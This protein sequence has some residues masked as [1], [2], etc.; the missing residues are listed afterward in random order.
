MTWEEWVKSPAAIELNDRWNRIW[1]AWHSLSYL[2][3]EDPARK[4]AWKPLCEVILAYV[5]S[6][7]VCTGIKLQGYDKYDPESEARSHAK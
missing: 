4:E 5:A 3:I 1:R 7:Y 6:Q 2:N